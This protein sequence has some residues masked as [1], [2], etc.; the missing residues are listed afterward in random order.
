MSVYRYELWAT[1]ALLAKYK[2]L[3]QALLGA[4]TRSKKLARYVYVYKIRHDQ[5]IAVVTASEHY[6][7]F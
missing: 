7:T 4:L 6:D 1:N 2:T 3:A 5:C